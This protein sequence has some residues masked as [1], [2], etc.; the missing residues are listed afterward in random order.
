MART[1]RRACAVRI[2][3]EVNI[4]LRIEMTDAERLSL[5]RGKVPTRLAERMEA[6]INE[7]LGCDNAGGDVLIGAEAMELSGHDLPRSTYIV[8]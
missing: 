3:A 7:R 5:R 8:F 1:K 2:Y 4:G 6:A